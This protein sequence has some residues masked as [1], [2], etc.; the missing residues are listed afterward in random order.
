MYTW[1]TLLYSLNQ[2]RSTNIFSPAILY[3][4][5]KSNSWLNPVCS[6]HCWLVEL[7]QACQVKYLLNQLGSNKLL[8][9]RACTSLPGHLLNQLGSKLFSPS[10][11]CKFTGSNICWANLVQTAFDLESLYKLAG[12]KV[13]WTNLVQVGSKKYAILQDCT[14]FLGQRAFLNQHDEP[15]WFKQ[16]LT[17]QYCTSLPGQICVQHHN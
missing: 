13:V 14:S 4:S 11:P 1:R 9:R 5:A 15:I 17:R 3:K 2:I 8:T 6:K 16:S 12:S 7:V 10:N